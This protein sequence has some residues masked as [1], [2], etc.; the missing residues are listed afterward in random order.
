MDDEKY[1]KINFPSIISS[2][3]SVSAF[4]IFS[5]PAPQFEKEEKKDGKTSERNNLIILIMKEIVTVRRS[6]VM[7]RRNIN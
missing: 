5:L 6:L 3:R 1:M 2:P 7:T 4:H